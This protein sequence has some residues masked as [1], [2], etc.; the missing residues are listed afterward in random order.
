MTEFDKDQ[1]EGMKVLIV[2]D[3]PANLDILGHILQQ[4][5]LEVSIAPDG[6]KA[7]E[8]VNRSKPDLIL[9]DIMMQGIDGYEV[10]RRLKADV[11]TKDIPV[12]FITALADTEDVM[13]AFDVGGIDHITKPFYEMEVICR[14]TT[15]LKLKKAQDEIKRR[16]KF[17]RVIVESVPDLIFQLDQDRKI[18]F[19]NPAFRLLGYDPD[20]L[21]GQPIG[22]LIESSD[23]ESLLEDLATRNVGPLAITDLEVTLKTS[24]EVSLVAEIPTHKTLVDSVGLWN[25]SDEDVFKENVDKE[26][27]GTLCVGKRVV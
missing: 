23:K 13:R 11:S 19:A 20:Q 22:N 21:V 3:I 17:Y 27:L 1:I 18:V 2:D 16:E 24:D 26:F 9:L 10:C 4:S 8:L 6:E 25:V 15:Q 14:I 12:I 5:G 7:L